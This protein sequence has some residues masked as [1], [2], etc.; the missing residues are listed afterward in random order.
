MSAS[1]S[2]S[3]ARGV[4]YRAE[5][6]RHPSEIK[7]PPA[8]PQDVDVEK[9]HLRE[10]GFTVDVNVEVGVPTQCLGT[11]EAVPAATVRTIP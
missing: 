5:H 4:A 2:G 8:I 3:L 11:R 1:S 10:A 9:S 6:R 7:Q